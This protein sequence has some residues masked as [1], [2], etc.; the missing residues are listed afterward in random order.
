MKYLHMR[1][2]NYRMKKTFKGQNYA[3]ILL[4]GETAVEKS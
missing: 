2:R 3:K 4:I 1:L